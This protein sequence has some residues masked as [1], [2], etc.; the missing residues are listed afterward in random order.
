MGN[1]LLEQ[2]R[3]YVTEKMAVTGMKPGK[4]WYPRI[5]VLL[6][7]LQD[8]AALANPSPW[9]A[10]VTVED[11]PKVKG[12]YL[13][14]NKWNKGVEEIYRDPDHQPNTDVWM[15]GYIAWRAPV[16][17]YQPATS[18]GQTGAESEDA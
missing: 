5:D 13:T 8:F 17:P 15:S 3:K 18:E 10:I 16:A 9:K 2:A 1:E 11:L 6:H 4:E 12:R 7:W 14:T